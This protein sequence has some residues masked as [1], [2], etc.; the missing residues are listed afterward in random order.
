MKGLVE[1]K[2]ILGLSSFGTTCTIVAVVA[3]AAATRLPKFLATR[4]M[5]SAVLCARAA[6]DVVGLAATWFAVEAL[7]V[8]PVSW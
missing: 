2:G 7:V 8:L 1:I 5:M 6:V 4:C 3:I